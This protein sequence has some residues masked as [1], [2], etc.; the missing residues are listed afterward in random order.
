MRLDEALTGLEQVLDGPARS[1]EPWRHLVRERVAAVSQ[2]LAAERDTAADPWLAAR[3]E[4]LR[5]ERE[6]L[7]ARLSVLAAL[8]EEPRTAAHVQPALRRLTRDIAH[9]H[10]RSTQLAYVDVALDVGGSD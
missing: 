8:I 5:R 10:A 3:T 7:L 1:Q 9:H 2:E 4:R 6:V